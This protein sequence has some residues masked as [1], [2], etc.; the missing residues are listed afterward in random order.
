[1]ERLNKLAAFVAAQKKRLA[2]LA[3]GWM[4]DRAS[5]WIFEYIL[6]P[7]VIGYWGLLKGGT[8]MIFLSV[9]LSLAE[10]KLYDYLKVDW[11]GI[12]TVKGIRDGE[13]K[14]IW[15]RIT[16]WAM[17]KGEIFALIV[18]SIYSEPVKVTLYMRHGSNKFN[19]FSRREWVI[20]LTSVLVG[21]ISWA[22]AVAG[23]WKIFRW[24]A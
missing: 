14:S 11:L 10:I 8:L 6:Y 5:N 7:V 4:T 3:V 16:K 1:M 23:G 13:A 18:L 22:I 20:F 17:K 19:G 24:L 21:N 12:E 15:R 2:I 9:T